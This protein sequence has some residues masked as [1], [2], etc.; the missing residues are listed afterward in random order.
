MHAF[1]T[2]NA[3]TRIEFPALAICRGLEGK[4]TASVAAI[5]S[6]RTLAPRQTV[7]C[8]GDPADNVYEVA[9]GMLKLFKLL[10]DG[11]RQVTGFLSPGHLLGLAHDEHYLYTA[12][13]VTEVVLCRYP[14]AQ[15]DRL[16]DEV[17]GFAR[18]LL[19]ATYDELRAAQDQML[20]LGRMEAAEKVASFL[21]AM[22]ERGKTKE[23]QE[24]EILVPMARND[25]A[26]YLG[27]T[28]ETVSRTLTQ[29]K[30]EGAISLSTPSHIVLR[31]RKRLEQLAE[32]GNAENA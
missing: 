9:R 8:E 5:A 16:V 19:A 20:L 3:A 1:T 24:D 13:A 18:R 32:G 12:E 10:P 2:L 27:L 31:N 29:L 11:R 14:R 7:F 15:F 22:A 28:T 25:I 4:A 21:L 17:P 26:D 6:H 23:G 30:R